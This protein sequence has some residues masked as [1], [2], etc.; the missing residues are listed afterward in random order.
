GPRAVAV[1][2]HGLAQLARPLETLRTRFAERGEEAVQVVDPPRLQALPLIDLSALPPAG[3]REELGRLSAED[4]VRLFDLARRPLLRTTLVRLGRAEHVFLL[5]QHHIISDA[6]SMGILIRELG[7]LY[8]GRTLPPLPVQYADFAVWQRQWGDELL[9]HQLDY[10]RR[11]LADAAP[12]ELPADRP[13]PAVRSGRGRTLPLTLPEPLEEA[14]EA[15][16]RERGATLFMTLL[17]AFQTLLHR[18]SGQRDVLVG[19]PVAGRRQAEVEGLIGFFVNMLVLRGNL[20]GEPA[21]T[22]VLE[23]TRDDALAAFCHQDLPFEQ[24]VE[25]LQPRRDRSRTPLFQVMFVLQNAPLE[26]LEL[27]DLTLRPLASDSGTSKVDLTLTLV[28]G[29]TGSIEYATELFDAATIARL[30][31]HFENLLGAVVAGPEERI[32]DLD[33]L[34]PAERWQLAGEWNAAPIPAA[35]AV[36]GLHQSFEA[37]AARTPEAVALVFDDQRLSYAELDARADELAWRLR[38]C[39]VGPEV[40]VG[41]ATPRTP[42]LVVSILG[43]LKAGG[44][45]VPIDPAYPQERREFMLDDSAAVVVLEAGWQGQNSAAGGQ[46]QAEGIVDGTTPVTPS[47]QRGNRPRLALVSLNSLAYVIYTSGSTGRAKGVA[48]THRS[49]L[50]LLDW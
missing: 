6:W 18:Y 37:Q 21:F 15:L 8:G 28:P 46:G 9:A 35:A 47:L 49:A 25:E 50:A 32:R 41:I 29:L 11:R 23:R 4:A 16:G 10:W 2:R 40:R 26:P 13:R 22:E 1:H 31:R 17:A 42:E 20:G 3:R 30:G 12:L 45:Y 7:E 36:I 43:V 39:G 14:L 19:T 44:A 48:I 38:G 24:L 33:L 5:N 27:P 34:T